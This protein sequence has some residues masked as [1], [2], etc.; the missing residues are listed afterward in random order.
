MDD[1]TYIEG[2]LEHESD[3]V[4]EYSI[5]A[6][7]ALGENPSRLMEVSRFFSTLEEIE[8]AGITKE[9]R[10]ILAY[11]PSGFNILLN[12]GFNKSEIKKEYGI[13]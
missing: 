9:N 7:W 8:E 6:K 2:E 1:L 4:K 12:K 11:S 13:R 10:L 3:Y 5:K